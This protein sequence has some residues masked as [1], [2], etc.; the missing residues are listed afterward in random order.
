MI[1]AIHGVL[2]Y[3]AVDVGACYAECIWGGDVYVV[4]IED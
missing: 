2:Y 1:V 4:V 3:S